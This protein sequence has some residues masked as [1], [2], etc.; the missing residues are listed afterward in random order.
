MKRKSDE[1]PTL[2]KK[3]KSHDPQQ[4]VNDKWYQLYQSSLQSLEITDYDA[5]IDSSL[6]ALTNLDAFKTMVLDNCAYAYAMK[7]RFSKAMQAADKM[8]ECTPRT[9]TGYL[10]AGDTLAL[11]GK[12]SQAIQVY[13]QG[14][15]TVSI[16]DNQYTSLE[17]YKATSQQQLDK[18]VDFLTAL[19]IDIV[20]IIIDQLDIT[21]S[22]I[23]CMDV[24]KRWR[25]L[26][27]D[28]ALGWKEVALE[29]SMADNPIFRFIPMVGKHTKKLEVINA[30]EDTSQKATKA[31]INGQFSSVQ[32][33]NMRSSYIG[34]DQLLLVLSR[35]GNTLTE[36]MLKV[37]EG[38]QNLHLES[39]LLA[40]P[41]L[42]H[43]WYHTDTVNM[44]FSDANP[45]ASQ[46]NIKSLDLETSTL[47]TTELLGKMIRRCPHLQQLR[48]SLCS[49]D[50]LT[51]INE[52]CPKLK[53][54]GFNGPA[55]NTLSAFDDNIPGIQE[56]Y[57]HDTEDMEPEHMIPLIEKSQLTSQSAVLSLSDDK[58]NIARRWN[59]LTKI[60]MEKLEY[61]TYCFGVSMDMH[62]IVAKM[63]QNCKA[64]QS[65][66]IQDLSNVTGNVLEEA[67]LKLPYLNQVTLLSMEAVN[68]DGF[69]YF[70]NCHADRGKGS[71]LREVYL[72]K[73]D[74]VTDSLL[75][76]LSKIQTLSL[77]KIEKCNGLTTDGLV[78]FVEQVSKFNTLRTIYLQDMDT[79]TDLVLHKL[80]DIASLQSITLRKL[81]K[82]TAD[83]VRCLIG[84]MENLK[85]LSIIACS[86]ISLLTSYS[87]M[88][89]LNQKKKARAGT[90]N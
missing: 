27:A 50:A 29:F 63:M 72:E 55:P 11:Q 74:N 19:P 6:E 31:L 53:V 9:A 81:P 46:C 36:L 48:V 1:K 4:G 38:S 66:T 88:G 80:V 71:S 18:R 85:S 61:L 5:A 2:A 62:T 40:C 47:I 16:D 57:I 64:L 83:A 26:L 28:Y 32:H 20:Y 44:E 25:E 86:R 76:A 17:Q 3:R 8:I 37:S 42:E 70:L 39:I 7:G 68:V 78:A 58:N 49:A 54:L 89:E 13:D 21:A 77:V 43:L 65:V 14:L 45:I 90:E 15:E 41:K 75:E 34:R 33:L 79:V 84:V 87:I 24:S 51:L 69:E 73:C 12:H 60:K 23:C 10:R 30:D 59:G 56:L 67:L 52:Y 82:I 22:H 35:L